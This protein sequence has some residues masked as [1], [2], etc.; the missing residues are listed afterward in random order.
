[1]KIKHPFI[2]NT[3]IT[4]KHGPVSIDA[5]G[6]VDVADAVAQYLL[7]AGFV[8]VEGPKADPPKVIA[9]APAGF[10]TIPPAQKAEPVPVPKKEYEKPV[11][12]TKAMEKKPTKKR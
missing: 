5:T 6:H 12:K 4:T 1:M 11:V 8:A 9:L 2:T 7:T 3:I 10:D